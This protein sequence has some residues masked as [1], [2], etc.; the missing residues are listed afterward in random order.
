LNFASHF[1]RALRALA[2]YEP[3]RFPAKSIP[4]DYRRAAVLIPFWA[5]DSAV[6]VVVT[7]RSSHLSDHKGQV[8]FP[9][10]RL[11]AGE[12]WEQ[13]ALREA[14]EEVGLDPHAVEVV[15]RLDDAWSGA[16]HHVVPIVAWL[17]QR[18]HFTPNPREVA[19]I[20]VA[21]VETLL[22][23]ASLSVD[24][25]DHE[26]HQYVNPVLRWDGGDAYGLT[27]DLLLEAMS[28]GKGTPAPGGSNR[29]RDLEAYQRRMHD[30]THPHG[31]PPVAAGHRSETGGSQ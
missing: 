21:D 20:L 12:T 31:S 23:P 8:A 17:P 7:R 14:H 11:D 22:Q 24:T 2:D 26:G 15:G 16:G 6:R 4:A 1:E 5:E 19:E 25:F 9:G 10:G 30:P 29:L 27:A 3:L 18:P 13:A 28:W